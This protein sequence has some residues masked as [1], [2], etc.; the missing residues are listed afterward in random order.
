MGFTFITTHDY[1]PLTRLTHADSL[2]GFQ[3][4]E[5]IDT[6]NN[7]AL[8]I[9]NVLANIRSEVNEILRNNFNPLYLLQAGSASPGYF[10]VLRRSTGPIP[11]IIRSSLIIFD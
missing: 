2:N 5:N 3:F 8:T 6:M 10:F 1:D 7:I 9:S 4:T 11:A